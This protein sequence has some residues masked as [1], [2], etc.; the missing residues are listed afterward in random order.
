MNESHI[1]RFNKARSFL[2]ISGYITD[3]ENEKV[4]VR[5]KKKA[6]QSGITLVSESV[7]RKEKGN[8]SIIRK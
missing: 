4:K 6:E 3:A 8:G 1:D 2:Y 5:F 7:L